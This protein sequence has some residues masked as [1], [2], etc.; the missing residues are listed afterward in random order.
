MLTNI[1]DSIYRSTLECELRHVT[2]W[3]LLRHSAH[4]GR[5]CE[6]WS[7]DRVSDKLKCQ[8]G[9][10][11]WC[12]FSFFLTPDVIF[13]LAR[14]ILWSEWFMWFV[15]EFLSMVAGAA[16]IGLPDIL[17]S[18]DARHSKTVDLWSCFRVS[19]SRAL[20]ICCICCQL[21]MNFPL[22]DRCYCHTYSLTHWFNVLRVPGLRWTWVSRLPTWLFILICSRPLHLYQDRPNISHS[23]TPSHHVIFR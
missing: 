14:I 18:A 8:V 9:R 10:K 17:C 7:Q 3:Q 20:F 1:S 21:H 16:Q 11:D 13:V 4:C 19:I 23:L 6:L 15:A 22:I 2:W 12:F 5:S